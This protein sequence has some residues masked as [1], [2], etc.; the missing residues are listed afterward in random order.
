MYKI[1]RNIAMLVEDLIF[2]CVCVVFCS[3]AV[4][5]ICESKVLLDISVSVTFFFFIASY[6]HMYKT[7]IGCFLFC[8]CFSA[9]SRARSAVLVMSYFSSVLVLPPLYRIIG[10]DYGN[11]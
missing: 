3:S 11:V 8:F 2:Q 10:C 5:A 9:P 1:F 6:V 7:V 4:L